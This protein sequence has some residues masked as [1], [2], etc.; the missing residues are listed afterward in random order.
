MNERY[1]QFLTLVGFFVS[2][3]FC[4]Q[5]PLE[6]AVMVIVIIGSSMFFNITG[7][8]TVGMYTKYSDL[9][10]GYQ[11][12]RDSYEGTLDLFV[13]EIEKRETKIKKIE[14]FVRSYR[15]EYDYL[16]EQ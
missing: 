14:E 16:N 12:K 15:S 3:V 8:M 13:K 9:K 6:P 4:I 1:A 5:T 10:E 7:T 11:L 2:L